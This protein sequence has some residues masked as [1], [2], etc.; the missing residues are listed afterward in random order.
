MDGSGRMIWY[1]CDY[2]TVF[3]AVIICVDWVLILCMVAVDG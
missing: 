3:V 2:M 1:V